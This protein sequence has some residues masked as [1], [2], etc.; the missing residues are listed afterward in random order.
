M[1]L[2]SLAVD[3]AGLDS[4]VDNVFDTLSD[5][6][7][8]D[9][10]LRK[11]L[12]TTKPIRFTYEPSKWKMVIEHIRDGFLKI[13]KSPYIEFKYAA[14]SDGKIRTCGGYV[15][16]LNVAK[17]PKL[18]IRARSD[19]RLYDLTEEEVGLIL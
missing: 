12:S 1:T 4:A 13:D 19:I 5:K 6:D 8:S 14:L 10:I 18:L 7:L 15:S 9:R 17:L 2:P 11:E 16:K 3:K